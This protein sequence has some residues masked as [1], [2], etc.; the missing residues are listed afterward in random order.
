MT[1]ERRLATAILCA[2]ALFTLSACG[3]GGGGD[4]TPQQPPADTTLPT[5]SNVALPGGTTVNRTVSLSVTASDNVGVTDVRFYADGNLLGND[6]TSPYSFEWNTGGE[7]EGAHVLHAEAEDAAG[8]IARSGDLTVTV[9]NV[10]QYAVTASGIEENPPIDSQ[11]SA[12][13]DLTVNLATGEVTGSMSVTGITPIAAHIHDGFAGTNGGVVIGFEQ[14]GSNPQLF[15]IPAAA[16]L[17]ASGVDRLLEGGLYVNVHTSAVP[18]GEI[19]G[20]ILGADF[21]LRF[22]D[23]S[24]DA[25]VPEVNSLGSGRAAMTLNEVTGALIVQA[26][27]S[28][29]ADAVAAHVHEGYAGEGGPVLVGLAQDSSNA[30]RWFVEDGTLNAAGLSAFAAGRL[31]VNVHTPANPGGEIRGQLLPEDVSVIKVAMSGA[32]EV[33]AVET[34]ARGRAWVTF[35]AATGGNALLTIHAN[36]SGLDDAVAAHLHL[37]YAGT[38]GPVQIGLTQD[39]NDPGHWFAEEASLTTEQLLGFLVGQTYVNIHSPANPGGEI[40]GQVIPDDLLFATGVFDGSEV[41][42]PTNTTAGGSYAITVDP[43]A[44]TMIAHVNTI[45]VDDATAAHLH[46][47]YAGSAGGVAI[48]LTQDATTVSRWSANVEALTADQLAAFRAGRLYANVHTP[49]FPGGEIR[50]QVVP[51]PIE[52]LFTTLSGAEEVPPVA[53]AVAATAASTVNRETGTIT[54]HLRTEGADDAVGSHIHGGFAGQNGGVVVGLEQDGGDVAHWFVVEAQLDEAGLIDYLDGRLYVNL[55]TPANPSGEVRGQI[56]PRDIQ[57]VFTDLT[58]DAVVPPVVTA[59]SGK[60]ST[61]TNLATRSMVAFVNNSGADDATAVGI[62]T[63]NAGENGAEI[64][65]LEQTSGTPSQW[66][67]M[68]ELSASNFANYRAGGLYALVT[69]PANA[70]GTLRGQIDPPDSA[71]FDTTAP[72]VTMVSP[73]D[74]VSG[75]VTLEATATD[76]QAVSEVRFL[77]DGVVVGTDN[78]APYSVSWDSVTVS[79]GMVA[80]TAEADDEAGN[81]GVSAAVNVTVENAQPVSLASDI[82]PTVFTPICAGCHS[83]GGG[84]LPSSLNLTSAA[85]SHANLVS[86]ASSQQQALNLVEPGNPDDSYLIRKLEG[87]PNISGGQMPQGGPFLS[88]ATIDVIRQWITEGAQNN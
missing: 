73:G 66:S 85:D 34:S 74:T 11:G 43:A 14:D 51:S 17:D 24:G 75:M 35:N 20:Q 72:S 59:A 80:L 62:H 30:E 44:M 77:V 64:L 41:I 60:A 54:L 19:R 23:L 37:A 87:G 33:P 12:Q 15:T 16:V 84:S 47:A 79:N 3:G 39:G 70:N 57:I 50:G 58:G 40:R 67:I 4:S 9:A 71:L 7:A 68:A 86:V 29:L 63:G 8:N 78:A 28:G 88:Q 45:G 56:A 38:N 6:T 25:A 5:V 2:I 31:Y 81:T 18:T 1:S 65:A 32:Q 69:T 10:V 53:S 76:N 49:A 83:G 82:Q 55:H 61:T 42:P 22:A 21:V 26:Q 46:D 48:P 13:A 36:A 27:V 52:V